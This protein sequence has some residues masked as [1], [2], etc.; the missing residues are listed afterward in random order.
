MIHFCRCTTSLHTLFQSLKDGQYRI[1][2]KP[3]S[4]Q[5]ICFLGVSLFIVKATLLEK[6]LIRP[7]EN[8]NH[9]VTQKSKSKV[10][11][12]SHNDNHQGKQ[13]YRNN[14]YGKMRLITTEISVNNTWTAIFPFIRGWFS[15]HLIASQKLNKE[16]RWDH[17]QS[18][19]TIQEASHNLQ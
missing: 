16:T 1:T 3:T 10:Q 17:L 4:K 12:V 19:T 6:L 9:S 5:K 13:F 2:C 14:L 8:I 11:M 7:Q 15:K 18:F